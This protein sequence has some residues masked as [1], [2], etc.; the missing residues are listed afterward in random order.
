MYCREIRTMFKNMFDFLKGKNNQPPRMLKHGAFDYHGRGLYDSAF[1]WALRKGFSRK[2]AALC[3]TFS[4]MEPSQ[5]PEVT[6]L[7][8]MGHNPTDM[9][10]QHKPPCYECGLSSDYKIGR[11]HYCAV[12]AGEWAMSFIIRA[13]LAYDQGEDIA[14]T[15]DGSG[16]DGLS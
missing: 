10:G 14:R 3:A 15:V 13:R 7:S 16:W 11:R 8:V 1:R 5:F 12:H 9:T 4:A 2:E 6:S